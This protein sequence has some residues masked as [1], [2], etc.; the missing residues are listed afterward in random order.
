TVLSVNDVPSFTLTTNLIT[1]VEDA[2]AQSITNFATNI[3]AGPANE[4]AQALTFL[5]T[6]TNSSFF[7]AQ[8]AISALGTLT[9]QL[10]TN[11]NGTNTITV[12]LKDDGGTNNS[13]VDTSGAQ[14][15]TIVVSAVN[16]AP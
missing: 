7:S 13:G 15:F 12:S 9:F 2:S 11:V 4:S 3:S 5:V 16:D 6:T 14:T 10:A 8:P 1:L